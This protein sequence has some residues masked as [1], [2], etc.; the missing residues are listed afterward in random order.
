M[1]KTHGTPR[2]VAYLRVSTAEQAQEY[3]R[4]FPHVRVLEGNDEWQP[5]HG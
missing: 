3:K 5:L 4:V 1:D 2:L